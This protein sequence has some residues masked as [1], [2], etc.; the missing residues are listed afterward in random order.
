MKSMKVA[1]GTARAKRRASL[2]YSPRPGAEVK[3][4]SNSRFYRLLSMDRLH[5]L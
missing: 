3:P 4:L 2:D 5:K 1:R